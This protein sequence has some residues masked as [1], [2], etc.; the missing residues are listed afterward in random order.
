[1][2]P[3][4]K[5][6]CILNSK[7]E[8]LTVMKKIYIAALVVLATAALSSCVQEKSFK[9]VK[10][11]EKD[12]VFSLQGSA[13][14][15]S[16]EVATVQKGVKLELD[17][18]ENGQ[19]L[20][21][22]ETIED[23]NSVSPA[24]KGTPA[25]TENVGKLYENM[26]VVIKNGST[27][28]L[29]TTGFYAMD[30]EIYEDGGW[31]YQGEFDGWPD[32]DTDLDFYLWM[33][34]DAT[35][36][37]PV[38][39][40]ASGKQTITFNYTSPAKAEDQQDLIFAARPL[41]KGEH[42]TK[43]PA[44]APVLFN[45]ALTAVKFAI[46]NYSGPEDKNITIKSI[47]FSGL[48][49]SGKCVITP[50]SENSYRDRPTTEY[51]SS[52]DGV[53]VWTLGSTTAEFTNNEAFGT[54]VDF[55]QGGSFGDKGKYPDSFAGGGNTKNLNKS[56]A[57]QTF[58]F[59][60]QAMN[61]DIELTIVYTFGKKTDGSDNE[62]TGVLEFGKALSGVTW[63][64]GQL[65]TYTIR[66]D[67]VNVKIEDSVT[68]DAHP[69]TQLTTIDGTEVIKD[70][71]G[72]PYLYTAYDGTKTD[73]TITNTGNT[74][75]YIRAALIGQWLD[76]NGNPVF[77]FTDYT[78][79]K[80]KLVDSWYQDQFVSHNGYHGYFEDLA[81]YTNNNKN[82]DFDNPL[83]NWFLNS[84]GYYYYKNIVPEG[85][86]IPSDNPLFTSYTVSRNPAVV[87]AGA[88]K[89]VYFRLEISTQAV[90]AKKSDGT[91]YSLSEAWS[92]AGVTVSAE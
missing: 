27:E 2:E 17:A 28:L 8:R 38:Y 29:N 15:R 60:P 23:L 64:A 42:D 1:M 16:A 31:R 44:G 92:R 43:L 19:K 11:G 26:G 41:S 62:M 45:H 5:S 40:K 78:A 76:E 68:A 85:E 91:D 87:V 4:R 12:I 24:T 77:G 73:V 34:V 18:D 75:A 88:V 39:G 66:V 59:I 3:T 51:S 10:I 46:E 22:E 54:P 71:N 63:K 52:A 47:T 86:S 37:N 56:D 82:Y 67:E 32:E 65:R 25:Y 69:N 6:S 20:Y 49:N 70:K 35:I 90:S 33:P 7:P 53:V 50:A 30:D 55:N 9:D 89:D 36:T 83:N 81:G 80:V 61:D 48:V 84:D 14:T 13:S 74:D 79:G 21:L 72:N 57:S 58:W